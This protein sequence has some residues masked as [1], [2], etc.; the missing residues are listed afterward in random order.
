[1]AVRAFRLTQHT[2]LPHMISRLIGALCVLSS[3]AAAPAH[4]SPALWSEV[5]SKS[6]RHLAQDARPYIRRAP[7]PTSRLFS[8]T[9]ADKEQRGRHLEANEDF[10]FDGES[11]GFVDGSVL[12]LPLCTGGMAS[13]RLEKTSL[14]PAEMQAEYPRIRAY[15]G[16]EVGAS[17]LDRL[18]HAADI[19]ITPH[20]VRA[21]IWLQGGL[22]E[23][24]RCFVDPH[25]HSRTDLY[26]VYSSLDVPEATESDA[27]PSAKQSRR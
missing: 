24:L 4:A 12:D 13:F 11:A 21:Q 3:A 15:H 25:S 23:H 26:T 22:D 8:L 27:A 16:F 10:M 5:T 19:T 17:D 6:G 18:P 9:L 14:L 7:S 1:L 2:S 20:G